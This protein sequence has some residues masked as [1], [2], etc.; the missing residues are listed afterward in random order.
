MNQNNISLEKVVKGL[1]CCLSAS[2]GEMT[3]STCM[4]RYD[5][6]G[7]ETGDCEINLL[8][9]AITMLKAQESMRARL[10]IIHFG[11]GS[12]SYFLHCPFDGATLDEG[13]NYCRRCGRA[14]KW[15]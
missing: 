6:N 12:K 3:C 4:Y 1:E 2:L 9:D 7:V 5:E 11:D 13:D 14:V 8:K 10:G 15:E